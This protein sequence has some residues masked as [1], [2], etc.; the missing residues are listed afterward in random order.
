MW[1]VFGPSTKRFFFLSNW[2][3][4]WF[5]LM[6]QI[7]HIQLLIICWWLIDIFGTLF[8]SIYVNLIWRKFLFFFLLYD[9]KV[10]IEV[11]NRFFI[12]I[13]DYFHVI[14]SLKRIIAILL[15]FLFSLSIRISNIFSCL[16]DFLP[17]SK[18]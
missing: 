12:T 6:I 10:P 3:F 15:M 17:E 13:K 11:G 2:I 5:H 1:F 16:Y 14:Q 4:V 18:S 8:F 9:I 7:L